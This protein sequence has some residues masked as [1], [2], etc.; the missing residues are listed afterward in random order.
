M[1]LASDLSVCVG[2]FSHCEGGTAGE[3]DAL[4]LF[5]LS[6]WDLTAT[7]VAGR[8]GEGADHASDYLVGVGSASYCRGGYD[9]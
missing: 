2:S 3:D 8:T 7:V 6:K 9:R 1:A 4:P 5:A